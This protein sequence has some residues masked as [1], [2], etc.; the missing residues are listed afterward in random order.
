MS[1]NTIIPPPLINL[2]QNNQ[3]YQ[4][5]RAISTSP[6]SSLNFHFIST[7]TLAYTTI[8]STKASTI[9]LLSPVSFNC[10]SSISR[11]ATYG[12]STSVILVTAALCFS[13]FSCKLASICSYILR[14]S[15]YVF[16]SVISSL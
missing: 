15:R 14:C 8:S 13:I 7:L 5:F 9:S 4:G 16:L 3:Y 12:T 10:P 2:H 1:A 11:P 6:N